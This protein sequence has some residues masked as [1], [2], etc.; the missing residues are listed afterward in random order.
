[1]KELR[2]SW[3]SMIQIA[4]FREV[5]INLRMKQIVSLK[6]NRKDNGRKQNLKK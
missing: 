6:A 5:R 1:M 2:I 3:V 4:L